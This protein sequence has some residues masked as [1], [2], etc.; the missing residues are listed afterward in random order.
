MQSAV[1]DLVIVA[2]VSILSVGLLG[3]ISARYL[4]LPLK[5]A[6]SLNILLTTLMLGTILREK[7]SAV[8]P[9]RSEP[10]AVS[11][12]AADQFFYDRQFSYPD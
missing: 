6:P 1:L 12:P 10:K 3:V 8:L 5:A 2:A 9:G 4:V 7:R 11:S